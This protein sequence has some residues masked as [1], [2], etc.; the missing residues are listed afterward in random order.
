[1]PIEFVN[2]KANKFQTVDVFK[3]KAEKVML[4]NKFCNAE[5][6]SFFL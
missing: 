6:V 5:I 4:E 2:K 1:M 3:I